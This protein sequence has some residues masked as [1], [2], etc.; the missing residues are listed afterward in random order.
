MIT[1]HHCND[2]DREEPKYSDKNPSD[3]SPTINPTWASLGLNP[4][5]CVQTPATN[6]LNHGKIVAKR[7]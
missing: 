7:V 3:S 6:S 4:D 1:E 2:T 5:Y